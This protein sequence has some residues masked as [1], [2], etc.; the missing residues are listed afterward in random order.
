VPL[1]EISQEIGETPADIRA[2][3]N[4]CD[5]PIF[6]IWEH[7]HRR[8]TRSKPYCLHL[9]GP[10]HVCLDREDSIIGAAEAVF[11][12]SGYTCRREIGSEEHLS[13]LCKDPSLDL[14]EP[15]SNLRD[16]WALKK[17]GHGGI[18]LFILEAKGKQAGQFDFYCFAE[19]LGQVFPV[20]ASLLSIML[21]GQKKRDGHG[22]TRRGRIG[23]F[24]P[25]LR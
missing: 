5:E 19:A 22:C 8:R 14:L 23:A 24:K 10:A 9:S 3:I 6:H 25:R 11:Q 13:Y 16:L 20:R 1:T 15:G 7:Q 17:D 4:G 12:R 18:D 2:F 21:G